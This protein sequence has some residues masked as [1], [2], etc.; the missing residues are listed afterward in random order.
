MTTECATSLAQEIVDKTSGQTETL[1]SRNWPEMRRI[2]EK[3]EELKVTL[4]VTITDRKTEPGEQADKSNRI[5]T[6]ISFSERFTDSVEA[7]LEESDSDQGQLAFNRTEQVQQPP[8]NGATTTLVEE[9]EADQAGKPEDAPLV[10]P[11]F[12][13]TSLG[14]ALA[15]AAAGKELPTVPVVIS[16]DFTAEKARAQF[17]KAAK[18]TGWPEAAIDLLDDA[19]KAAETLEGTLAILNAHTRYSEE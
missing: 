6:T 13:T 11:A 10:D 14:E 4:S 19:A 7:A 8:V 2:L 15:K 16:G 17:R 12:A 18:K 5:K 1:I 3:E 9:F